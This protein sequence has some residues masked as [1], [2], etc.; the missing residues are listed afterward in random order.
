MSQITLKVRYTAAIQTQILL[1]M[2]GMVVHGL[3]VF[4]V[5]AP[6]RW[7]SMSSTEVWANLI[8][9]CLRH[10]LM[11]TSQLLNL[12]LFLM[13]LLEI[14]MSLG[15][16]GI[17]PKVRY[18][19]T[20]MT[21][22]LCGTKWMVVL[23]PLVFTIRAWWSSSSTVAW[24]HQIGKCLRIGHIVTRVLFLNHHWWKPKL[25]SGMLLLSTSTIT[26]KVLFSTTLTMQ[27]WCTNKWMVVL[28]P[29]VFMVQTCR[30]GTSTVAW[31]KVIGPCLRNGQLLIQE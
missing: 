22:M 2:I 10:G 16:S 24:A 28:G 14:G 19:E 11:K 3:L 30:S 23:G 8:G 6:V 25:H 5:Q 20:K 26:L 21:L 29:V 18:S 9:T 31:A 17:T 27:K 15:M 1:T 13:L 4:M 7:W 12:P